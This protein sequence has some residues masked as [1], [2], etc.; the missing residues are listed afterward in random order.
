MLFRRRQDPPISERVRIALWPRRS[1]S[2]STKYVKHRVWRLRGSPHAIAIGFAAGVMISFTPFVGFHFI[3]AALLALALGGSV[4]ASAFGTF[5]GNP[6]TFPFIW[7][8]VYKLGNLLLGT[9]GKF[10]ADVLI[11]GFETLWNGIREFSGDVLWGALEI[12][13][14]LIKPMTVG[15]L[16]MGIVAATIFYFLVLKAVRSYQLRRRGAVIED[17]VDLPFNNDRELMK[18]HD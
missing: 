7:V 1:W 13:W 3:G 18:R 11:S 6:I 2:R 10:N 9:D 16:P 5:V 17:Y 15:A 14:P 8:G 4:I 12:L